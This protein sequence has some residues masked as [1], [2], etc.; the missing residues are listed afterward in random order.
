MGKIHLKEGELKEN[1]RVL[2]ID[3]DDD[4]IESLEQTFQKYETI[5]KREGNI[6]QQW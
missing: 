4:S 2:I 3:S 5:L 1:C 6:H